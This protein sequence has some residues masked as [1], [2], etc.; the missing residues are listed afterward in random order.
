ML[1]VVDEQT[2]R[3]AN[4][5]VWKVLFFTTSGPAS[6]LVNMF[7]GKR[8]E[9]GGASGQVIWKAL[10]GKTATPKGL[11]G[12]A[13]RSWLTRGWTSAR[14]PTAFLLLWTNTTNLLRTWSRRFTKSNTSTL[15][16]K[17]FM[18]S[19]KGGESLASKKELQVGRHLAHSAH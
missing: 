13:T 2:R 5:D 9:N 7:E 14:I 12:Y 4:Q 6:K 17:I 11:A 15:Y 3:Q 1:N 8:L 10:R 16:F 19:T 18:P